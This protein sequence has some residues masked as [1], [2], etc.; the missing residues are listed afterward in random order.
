M[1]TCILV[2][3]TLATLTG[4]CCGKCKKK[5][6]EGNMDKIDHSQVIQYQM[7]EGQQLKG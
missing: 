3:L 2:L 4:C 1:K 7:F 5:K 6:M